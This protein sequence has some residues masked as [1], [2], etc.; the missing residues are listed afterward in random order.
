MKQRLLFDGGWLRLY[1]RVRELRG[2]SIRW[3]FCSRRKH[4]GGVGNDAV[5]IVPFVLT[6]GVVKMLVTR[7]YRMPLGDYE[8]GLPSGLIE[9]GEDAEVAV[10]RELREETGYRLV[11]ILEKSPPGLVSSA[12]LS[13][14]TFQY[15]FVQAVSGEAQRLE[16]AEEIEVSLFS[17]VELG[18]LME[19][20]VKLSGRLWPLVHGYLAQ[21]CF[22][23]S[24]SETSG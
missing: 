1:E 12:G 22:P 6:G 19:R 8:W 17:L 4:P 23:I 20:P 24:D 18:E 15:F 11:R 14:E 16:S 9:A 21:G 3:V 7:E 13:D 5:V 10:D 2:R